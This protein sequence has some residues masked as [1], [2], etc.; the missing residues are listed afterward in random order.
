MKKKIALLSLLAG[1]AFG[2]EES[3]TTILGLLGNLEVVGWGPSKP[4]YNPP[5]P[6]VPKGSLCPDS[7]R[8]GIPDYL[9][10]CPDTPPGLPVD[11]KGCPVLFSFPLQLLFDFNRV[12]IKKIYYPQLKKIAQ[13]LRNN[14]Y[15]KI[16]IAGYTDDVG[17]PEFNKKLSYQRALAV[18]ETLVKH[19][20]INP[21]RIVVK[22]YGE[23]HPLVPNTTETNRALN[24]RVDIIDI[25]NE[26][27]KSALPKPTP[28]Q[29]A[30][31]APAP[32]VGLVPVP[33]ANS[34]TRAK[35]RPIPGKGATKPLPSTG[36][37]LRKP[38]EVPI[39]GG[40]VQYPVVETA[41]IP[42]QTGKKSSKKTEQSP[43]GTYYRSPIMPKEYYLPRPV[44][45]ESPKPPYQRAFLPAQKWDLEQIK[46][47][48]IP[49]GSYSTQ[50]PVK[51]SS[52]KKNGPTP[53]VTI[54][55]IN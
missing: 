51:P 30:Y 13:V 44:V 24:R 12:K 38:V 8:D 43:K 17:S 28:P 22:G 21:D 42:A 33:P 26:I 52:D 31:C 27:P 50:I 35:G 23:E 53:K 41:E 6:P 9:D 47:I 10:R 39:K 20:G 45:P 40:K 25:T 14:P 55:Y 16:E 46:V 19:F 7:D 18:K 36:Q 32:K 1:V 3:T 29:L 34:R 4:K 2:I 5:P 37:V 15:L 49:S 11:Q 54:E 48:P